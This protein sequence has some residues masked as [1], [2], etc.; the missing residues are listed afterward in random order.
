MTVLEYTAKL[1]T[2]HLECEEHGEPLNS[3]GDCRYCKLER[4]ITTAVLWAGTQDKW[5]RAR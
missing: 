4:Q 5:R 2:E 1:A 3:V